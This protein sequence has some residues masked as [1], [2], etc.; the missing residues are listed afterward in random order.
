MENYD[1]CKY[2]ARLGCLLGKWLEE[3][4]RG[5]EI[6]EICICVCMCV[7]A[8]IFA[9]NVWHMFVVREIREQNTRDTFRKYVEHALYIQMRFILGLQVS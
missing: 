5:K 6:V 8:C 2:L 7:H 9:L 3:K 4:M 1:L